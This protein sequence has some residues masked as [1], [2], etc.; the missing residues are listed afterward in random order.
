[1]P[2]SSLTPSFVGPNADA[3]HLR[4]EWADG[5]SSEFH[6]LDLRLACP[7][8]GCVDEMTGKPIL[9]PET[10]DPLVHPLKIEYVGRYAIRFEWSDGHGTGIFPFEFLRRLSA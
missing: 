1:M 10:V 8:A 5:A 7:C 9:R 6:P 3:T 4:I 2:D